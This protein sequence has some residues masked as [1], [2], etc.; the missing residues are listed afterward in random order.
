MFIIRIAVGGLLHARVSH[1]SGRAAR[2][3]AQQSARHAATGQ[4]SSNA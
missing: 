2:L 4:H 1:V 3:R